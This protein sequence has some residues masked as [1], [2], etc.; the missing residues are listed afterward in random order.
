MI[1]KKPKGMNKIRQAVKTYKNSIIIV[2]KYSNEIVSI[3]S[4]MPD[5]LDLNIYMYYKVGE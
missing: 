3:L 5:K 4:K 1:Y 2:N